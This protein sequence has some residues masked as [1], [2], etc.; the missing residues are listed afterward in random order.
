[1]PDPDDPDDPGDLGGR[2]E[3]SREVDGAEP[4]PDVVATALGDDPEAPDGG[5]GWGG[6][7]TD[8]SI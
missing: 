3:A 2:E 1:M 4:E 8:A 7:G 6:W 5:T